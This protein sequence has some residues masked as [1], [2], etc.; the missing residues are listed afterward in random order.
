MPLYKKLFIIASLLLSVSAY[1]QEPTYPKCPE[2]ETA[3]CSQV[4]T[5]TLLYCADAIFTDGQMIMM[6]NEDCNTTT[7]EWVCECQKLIIKEEE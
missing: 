1:A 6:D 2:G 4:C 3:V 7:C 5:T